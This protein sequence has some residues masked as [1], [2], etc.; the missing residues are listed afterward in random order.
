MALSLMDFSRAGPS[1]RPTTAHSCY[2][3]SLLNFVVGLT[4][5][6]TKVDER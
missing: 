6:F 5:F 1:V 2:T 3:S 4:D